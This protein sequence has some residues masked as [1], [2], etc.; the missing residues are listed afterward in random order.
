MQ[1]TYSSIEGWLQ[2]AKSNEATVY[3]KGYLAK[4]R[5]YSNETRDIANLMLRSSDNNIVVLYQKRVS[6]GT[7]SKDPVY[8]YIAKKI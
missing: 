5:F 1:T 3:H 6:Y 8:N 2:T 4:D 7:P